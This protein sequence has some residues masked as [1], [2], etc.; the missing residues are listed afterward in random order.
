MLDN[1][2]IRFT[3]NLYRQI[4]G[5]SLGTNCAHLIADLFC[6]VMRDLIHVVSF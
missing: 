1:I 3:F 2:F 4:V 6:F 5:V